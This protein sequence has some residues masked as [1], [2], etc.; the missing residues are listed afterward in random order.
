MKIIYQNKEYE[1]QEP[2]TVQKLLEKE[3]QESEHKVVGCTF[4]NE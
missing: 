4:N 3:I 1:I 2:I